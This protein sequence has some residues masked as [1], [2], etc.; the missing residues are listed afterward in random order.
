MNKQRPLLSNLII[1]GTTE[2]ES[3]QNS[4]LRPIIKMQNDLLLSL[5]EH[6][7]SKKKIDF[8]TL[9]I[10][11]RKQK[12]DSILSKDQLFKKMI[13]GI[14]V[15]QF[16]QEELLYYVSNENELNKRIISIVCQR[17]KDAYIL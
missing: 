11:K 12:T 16:T 14:V 17:I 1:S 13:I 15:G 5:F 2:L 9:S 8:L 7:L 4:T 10:E 6:Y 3:F